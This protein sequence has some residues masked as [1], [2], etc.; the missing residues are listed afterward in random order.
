MNPELKALHDE[1]SLLQKEMENSTEKYAALLKNVHP[2][3]IESA[4]NLLNYLILRKT[5]IQ[6]LQENL[7]RHGLSS[8]ASCE[9][10]THRQIQV[11]L[12]RLGEDFSKREAIS[13]DYGRAK[14]EET[15]EELFGKAPEDWPTSVM[16]TFDK[17]F[18]ERK[19]LVSSLL[20]N[21][22]R[23]A[24]INCAHDD[25]K[26]WKEMIKLIRNAS[27]KEKIPCKIHLDLAGPKLR[28]VLLGKGKN[29]GRI[30]VAKGDKIWLS[31]SIEGFSE[32]DLVINPGEKGVISDLKV[33][34]RVF[35]D[36]GLILTKILKKEKN[37]ALLVV[38][39][40]SS[41]KGRLKAEKGINF[42]DSKLQIPSLTEYDLECLEFAVEYA[43]TIGFSFVREAKDLEVLR[44]ELRKY[45]EDI[46][47]IIL[48]IETYESVINFPELLLEGMKEPSFGVMIARGD[49]AVEIGFG[50]LVEIQEEVSWLCE[51]AHV[52]VI[53]ATQ[54]LENLHKSGLASR[55]E[56]TD[57]GRAALAECI[58]I[59]KGK[60]TL[61]VL[62]ILQEITKRSR[63]LK[64]KN[65]LVFRPLS[66]AEHFLNRAEKGWKS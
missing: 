20:Q 16:V 61:S 24:R 63:S 59:N 44:N 1:L 27:K 38:E 15:A 65:R 13:L 51:A 10:H 66:I 56:I 29:S 23:I 45:A 55:A 2:T 37:S 28:T 49:L 62:K 25:S 4:K 39:R 54:V 3:Q 17:E 6:D 46:P 41:K 26:I 50:R 52:S 58:M 9:S 35:I 8:L 30:E 43:D 57:A 14:I 32:K 22:M 48:K 18:L 7:H 64:M 31:E 12:E 40:N 5:D 42:P 36:D 34:E 19:E 33:G 60:H 47:P 11:T 21:G 53:W